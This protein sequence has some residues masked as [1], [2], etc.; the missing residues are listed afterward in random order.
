MTYHALRASSQ[1]VWQRELEI[2]RLSLLSNDPIALLIQR[3]PR[4]PACPAY[5][6]DLC[7]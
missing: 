5:R 6:Q 2:W 4:R 3:F 1:I 7:L